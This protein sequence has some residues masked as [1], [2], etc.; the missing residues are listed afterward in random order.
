MIWSGTVPA[1]IAA[2]L[3]SIRVSATCTRPT[4]KVRRSNPAAALPTSSRRVIRRLVPRSAR[5]AAR[6]VP[7]TR[8]RLPAAKSGGMVSTATL[9][10]KY[11]EPH[12]TQ[13]VSRAIQTCL[14]GAVI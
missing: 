10:P 13:T 5:T 1:I 14:T 8:K 9:I 6:I 2:T 12:T 3:E 11:V 7:A 4:P